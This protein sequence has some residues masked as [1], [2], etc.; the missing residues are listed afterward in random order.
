VVLARAD[1]FALDWS[2]NDAGGV[3]SATDDPPFAG[4][5]AVYPDCAPAL[6]DTDGNGSM[7]SF[8]IDAFV[9]LLAGG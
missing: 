6:A 8:D 5:C 7:D 4:Y 1:D 9:D 2:T 3:I